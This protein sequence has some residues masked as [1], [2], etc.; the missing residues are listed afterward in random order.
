[1]PCTTAQL[2]NTV[3]VKLY[4][5]ARSTQSTPG[6]TDDKTYQLGSTTLNAF[7]D[8]YKRH[9]FSTTVRLV[10]ISGRRETP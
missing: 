8:Q 7:G 6:Y 1:V 5:L 9:V 10:N 3:A 2:S 4:V